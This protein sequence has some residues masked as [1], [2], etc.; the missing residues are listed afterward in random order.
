MVDKVITTILPF[1]GVS[2]DS[3]DTDHKV[4]YT[5]YMYL[6][7]HIPLVNNIFML[8]FCEDC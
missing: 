7:I 4:H 3:Y 5:R 1:T 8:Q 2:Q 6:Y